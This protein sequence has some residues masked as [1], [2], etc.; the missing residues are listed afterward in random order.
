[1]VYRRYPVTL[2]YLVVSTRVCGAFVG[3]RGRFS[4]SSTYLFQAEEYPSDGRSEGDGHASRG[5][6]GQDLA[7]LSL[8]APVLREQV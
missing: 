3:D 2:V 6:R 8:V 1:M 5:R 4:A 7:L